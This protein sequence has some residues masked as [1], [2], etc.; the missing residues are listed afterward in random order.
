MNS[1]EPLLLLDS[2]PSEPVPT[3]YIVTLHPGMP[4]LELV[5]VTSLDELS[6]KGKPDK[7]VKTGLAIESHLCRSFFQDAAQE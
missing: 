3:P 1:V 7:G 6:F 4:T 5:A 2:S